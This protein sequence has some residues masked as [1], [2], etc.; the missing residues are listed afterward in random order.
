MKTITKIL[1]TALL[2]AIYPTSTILANESNKADISSKKIKQMDRSLKASN[3]KRRT[4]RNQKEY[5]RIKKAPRK[6]HRA[7]SRDMR[8]H[9][10][11]DRAYSTDHSVKSRDRYRYYNDDYRYDTYERPIVRQRSYNNFKRGW[12]LAYLYDRASFNDSHGYHYGYFNRNGY[13]FDDIFYEYDRY[14][15]YRDRVRGMG[16]FDHRYYIPSNYNYYGFCPTRR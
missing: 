15:R 1:T 9:M 16:L 12:Y 3:A 7:S 11:G 10:R 2:L 5:S 4:F 13:Y 8:K 14:Y 6:R